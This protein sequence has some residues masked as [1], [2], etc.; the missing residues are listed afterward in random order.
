MIDSGATGLFLDT[1]F[2]KQH[3]MHLRPLPHAI[4]LY[5]I[6]GTSNSAGK[7]THLV[8]LLASIDG[9]SPQLLEFLVTHL[10]SEKVILGLPWLRHVNPKIDW[11]CGHLKVTKTPCMTIEE[12]PELEE[13]NSGKIEEDKPNTSPKSET[14][15]ISEVDEEPKE[16]PLYHL[17]GN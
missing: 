10:G 7:I 5:N 8:K 3:R 12:E 15:D 16:P 9:N 11:A 1:Q 2:A 17:N 13:V 4:K 6:D 14:D